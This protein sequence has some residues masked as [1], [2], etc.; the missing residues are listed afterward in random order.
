MAG[1]T[2]HL[3]RAGV[4]VASG[5]GIKIQVRRGH[6]LVEDGLGRDRRSRSF[7][8][9]TH[10]ISR[11]VVIGSDG[12]I[13]LEAT[14]WLHRLGIA[15]IH[16][17]RDG[18]ILATSTPHGGDAR[19]RRMQAA[20]PGSETGLE[21]ARM[22]LQAKLDGQ[23]SVLNEL[24][25]ETATRESFAAAYSRL[26]NAGS[27]DE[28][29]W[30]ERDAALAY[31]TAWATIPIHFNNRDGR[32]VPDHWRTFG[33]RGS[34]LTSSPRAAI[35]PANAILN[36]LY[37]ILEAE[38][39]LACLTVGLDPGL[40]IVHADYRDRDS[41]A[42]DLMEAAR[43]AVDAHV[44]ELLQTRAFT[45]RDFVET[46]RGVCRINPPLSHE[47]AE[48]PPLWAGAIAPAAEAV[49]QLLVS[50][51]GSRIKQLSTPLTGS[52]RS[53]RYA[54][55]RPTGAIGPKTPPRPMPTCK[56]CAGPLPRRGRVYCDDCLPH[57]QREQYQE[58][59]HSSG[60]AVIEHRKTQGADPTHGA[61][62]AG[63]RAATNVIRKREVREWDEQHGKLVD[64]SA[65]ERD[66]LPLIQGV[67][68]SRLQKATGLSLR[69]VSLIRRGERTP[70][71]RHW[72]AFITA[73]QV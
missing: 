1:L 2:H 64:L 50:S 5:Y 54:R 14:R 39:R 42:L 16:V 69:Y 8:R 20:A 51:D 40:G 49:A 37:A 34:P 15:L 6:L 29:V 23:A 11:L 28:L 46:A 9:A 4:C 13:T 3:R 27:L 63:R 60:L 67:P 41:F 52:K 12:F 17:D 19:L 31:W 53:A 24:P 7:S 45:R 62:A 21:V 38:T 43:P 33:Q 59:F 66:I 61:T 26:G 22:L 65:F 47:L 36:Y 72:Q 48:T 44:L 10:G 18:N 68:L 71:P 32:L 35:N 58:A 57:Y 30:A 25:A 55:K 56:R 70:H 73:A